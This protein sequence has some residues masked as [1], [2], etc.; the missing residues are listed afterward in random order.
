MKEFT[1]DLDNNIKV[2]TLED[3]KKVLSSSMAFKYTTKPYRL[4]PAV[5]YRARPNK[6]GEGKAIDFFNNVSDLWAPPAKCIGK[7]GRC[8]V[9]G[10]STLYCSTSITTTLFEVRPN[11]GEELTFIEFEVQNQIQNLAIIGCKEIAGLGG[12]W[13]DIFG[14]HFEGTSKDAEQLD[15]ILSKIYR[16]YH[17]QDYPIYN[18]TNAVFQMFMI[19]PQKGNLPEGMVADKFNGLIYPSLATDQLLGINMAMDPDAVKPL[20]KPINCFKYRVIE[21]V[22]EHR[23][24]IILT[25]RSANIEAD[26]KINWMNQPNPHEERITDLPA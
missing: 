9:A 7:D 10:Q 19:Q 15:D 3:W 12:A 8:N 5:L 1:V 20:L 14:R 2:F 26:G 4:N 21:K 13:T 11:T 16:M 18:I 17:K 24:R 25:H 22:D 23:Y 6:D